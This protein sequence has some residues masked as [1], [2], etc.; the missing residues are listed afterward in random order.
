MEP[1]CQLHLRL[2]C[3]SSRTVESR[4]LDEK[5][6]ACRAR[7]YSTLHLK[8]HWVQ[9]R[10]SAC[11]FFKRTQPRHFLNC[12]TT[13]RCTVSFARAYFCVAVLRR[14][15]SLSNRS[16]AAAPGTCLSMQRRT[17]VFWRGPRADPAGIL[18]NPA[19]FHQGR[20][21]ALLL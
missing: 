3:V 8:R 15:L 19:F 17:L 9:H 6:G 2:L 18:Y 4:A 7:C 21:C 1:W 13:D 20:Y 14:L 5:P 10:E 16:S 11:T 12:N